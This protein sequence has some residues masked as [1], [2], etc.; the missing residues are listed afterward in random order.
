[1]QPEDIGPRVVADD[2]EGSPGQPDLLEIDE[3]LS[4]TRVDGHGVGMKLPSAAFVLAGSWLISRGGDLAYLGAAM[5]SFGMAWMFWHV[6]LDF[7]RR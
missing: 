7:R 1:M 4:P 3:H 6:V 2:V 5:L